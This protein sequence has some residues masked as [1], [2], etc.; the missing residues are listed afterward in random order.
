MNTLIT[1]QDSQIKNLNGQI[2]V[3]INGE[4]H[5]VKEGEFIP[6]GAELILSDNASVNL[7]QADGNSVM[8]DGTAQQGEQGET[9][10]TDAEIQQLQDLIAAGEDPTANLPETA[11]GNEISGG[12]DSGYV[13]VTRDGSEVLASSGYDTATFTL[14]NT[15]PPDDVQPTL[16]QVL[17]PSVVSLS[18]PAQVDEGGQITYS[19]SVNNVPQSDLVLTLSNGATITIAAGQST[20]TVTVDAPSDDVYQD[21]ETLTVNV[22]GS[23]GGNYENLDLGNSVDTQVNDT[24]DT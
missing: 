2:A 20:G 22:T 12:G 1:Q 6:K 14:D 19:A 21:G 18:A 16:I 9:A 8:V 11:A 23:T 4:R 13:A 15:N 7:V 3:V 5:L 10:A 24:I 17:P